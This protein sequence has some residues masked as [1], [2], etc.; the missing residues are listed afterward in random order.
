MSKWW[1]LIISNIISY[2]F[3]SFNTA[4][5]CKIKKMSSIIEKEEIKLFSDN[6]ICILQK[7]KIINLNIIEVHH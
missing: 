1:A 2:K 5:R 3:R 4:L 7:S 6:M